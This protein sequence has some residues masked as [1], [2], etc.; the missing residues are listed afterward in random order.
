MQHQNVLF[1]ENFESAVPFFQ[2]II[3][4]SFFEDF[5]LFFFVIFFME[6]LCLNFMQCI[7]HHFLKILLPL[8]QINPHF[9]IHH[10]MQQQHDQQQNEHHIQI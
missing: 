10:L 9:L 5:S 4:S 3:E 8:N 1:L 7:H 2:K 6:S